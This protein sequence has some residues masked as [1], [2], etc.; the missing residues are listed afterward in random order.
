M[1]DEEEV[2]VALAETLNQTFLEYVGGPAHSMQVIKVHEK[3]CSLDESAVREK[4][5]HPS[6]LILLGD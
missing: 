6:I 5:R 2:L 4:V 3:L 1:D